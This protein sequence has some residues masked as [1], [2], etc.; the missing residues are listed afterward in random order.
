MGVVDMLVPKGEGEAAV[1]DLIRQQQRSPH[2]HLAL[3]AGARRSRSRW[4]TTS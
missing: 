4:A 2:A 3:N 1:Q